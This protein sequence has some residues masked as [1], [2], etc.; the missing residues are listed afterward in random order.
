MIL[1]R[2]RFFCC[3]FLLLAGPLPCYKLWWLAG[4][5]HTMGVVSFVGH[6]GI[7]SPL[8]ITSYPVI[9]FQIGQDSVFFNGRNGYGYKP[10]DPVPIRYRVSEP[11]DAKIDQPSALWGDTM[12][13]LL[14]PVLVWIVLVLTPERFEPLLPRGRKILVNGKP[15]FV[16]LV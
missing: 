16:W 13:Y 1:S 5:Q 6:S 11:T 9:L 10:G 14:F 8:G 4:T 3:L 2:G 15:P 12:V 7:E